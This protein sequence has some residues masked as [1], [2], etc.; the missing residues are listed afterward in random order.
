[1]TKGGNMIKMG[2]MRTV[3]SA[4]GV[5]VFLAL[6][7]TPAAGADR[8]ILLDELY[9]MSEQIG[10]NVH[11]LERMGDP[12][13]KSIP[14]LESDLQYLGKHREKMNSH[15]KR[16][17]DIQTLVAWVELIRASPISIPAHTMRLFEV[18]DE[19]DRRYADIDRREK[20]ARKEA[21]DQGKPF[22]KLDQKPFF[23]EYAKV[24]DWFYPE[25]KKVQEKKLFS[26]SEK[27]PSK[28]GDNQS[29]IIFRIKQI[30]IFTAR[31]RRALDEKRGKKPS[32]VD[33]RFF[34]KFRP[35]SQRFQI[36]TGES[37]TV[38]FDIGGGV[39]PYD[40]QYAF[41]ELLGKWGS[42]GNLP[43]AGVIQFTLQFSRT[44]TF[45]GEFTLFDAYGNKKVVR[46][47][48]VVSS[49]KKKKEKSSKP[50]DSSKKPPTPEKDPL[51]D[52]F[53]SDALQLTIPK[54]GTYSAVFYQANL[55]EPPKWYRK[56]GTEWF[57]Y[58]LPITLTVTADG[59]VTGK[60]DDKID[61]LGRQMVFGGKTFRT[62][63]D[64]WYA[65]FDL[66]G[67]IDLS[68]GH[69]ELAL[70]DGESGWH[71]QVTK[72]K[73]ETF[74]DGIEYKYSASFKGEPI[75]GPAAAQFFHAYLQTDGVSID[76]LARNDLAK[77]GL[78]KVQKTADGKLRF[79]ELG[80][81]G[82]GDVSSGV[83]PRTTTIGR[84]EQWSG[85]GRMKRI[86]D[87]KAKWQKNI[88]EKEGKN[89]GI[90][91]YLKILAVGAPITAPITAPAPSKADEDPALGA[92]GLWPRKPVQLGVG[93][94]TK[95]RAM[96]VYWDSPIDVADLTKKAEW[97][98]GPGLEMVG[99]GQFRAKKSG[100]YVVEA[101]VR[102]GGK[103]WSASMTIEVK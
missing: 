27:I 99:P 60:A 23:E 47:S 76:I 7:L 66:Q 25:L 30:A 44:G 18:R 28:L 46:V 85:W 26:V 101:T 14:Q 10:W 58:P 82:A 92:F 37:V 43:K 42:Q 67:Q 1:M 2:V 71:Y 98:A 91:W 102:D 100:T 16:I 73:G 103:E 77:M 75:P 6:N 53:T 29:K 19:R 40:V 12:E 22:T 89:T 56:K 45:D 50:A 39:P 3:V 5:V 17:Q 41:S 80:F 96:G 8:K 83:L 74:Y 88:D 81:F 55:H 54:A 51:T 86:V 70:S 35:H 48:F 32:D 62:T 34:L 49:S 52:T 24:D 20:K 21:R 64:I 36:E 68:T 63:D 84:F 94:E 78:P 4:V 11:F 97:R 31:V 72:K 9:A 90:L 95:A 93:D 65:R 33:P 57:A 59:H 69:I 61:R 15:W 79:P 87:E 13:S 38:A